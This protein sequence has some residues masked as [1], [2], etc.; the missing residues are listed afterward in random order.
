MLKT[1]ISAGFQKWLISELR[2]IINEIRFYEMRLKNF[3]EFEKDDRATILNLLRF[4][5]CDEAKEG[6]HNA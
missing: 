4:C 2:K 1:L 3:S 5:Y 6:L